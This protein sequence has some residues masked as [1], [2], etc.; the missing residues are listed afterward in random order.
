MLYKQIQE[1]IKSLKSL[2]TIVE[3]Y[4]EIAAIRMR[5]VKKSVLQNRAFISGLNDIFQRVERSYKQQIEELK[6]HKR[7]LKKSPVPSISNNGK[8]ICV[9]V[10]ANTGLYGSIIRNTFNK[11]LN[12]TREMDCDIVILGRLGKKMYEENESGSPKP[13]TYF[14]FPDTGY[15]DDYIKEI[16]DFLV[17][18]KNIIVFHGL[19]KDMLSQLA[20]KSLITRDVLE[21]S[22][23]QDAT[24]VHCIFEP[25]I[26]SIVGFFETQILSALF[27]QFIYESDLS[28]FASRMINL[29]LASVNISNKMKD[30]YFSM[31]KIDH[32]RKNSKQ[33]SMLTG[34]SLWG[35]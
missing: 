5:R 6:K 31:R 29:D 9:L 15:S 34:I 35:N 16:F 19:Y 23:S 33:L 18:Y 3:T 11:F 21:S 24:E 27:G 28:K 2:H 7:L 32:K 26:E 10:S 20:T 30:V 22:L 4:E 14:D 17:K 25:S 13:Y 12:E 8:T 1:E